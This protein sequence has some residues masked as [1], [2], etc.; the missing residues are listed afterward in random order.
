M[1]SQHRL[2]QARQVAIAANRRRQLA[3][4]LERLEAM[5]AARVATPEQAELKWLAIA[6]AIQEAGL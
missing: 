5:Q 6:D 4:L 2:A 3:L 1:N